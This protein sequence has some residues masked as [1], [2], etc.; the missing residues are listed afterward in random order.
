MPGKSDFK[1]K[2]DETLESD[3]CCPF[4]RDF[5]LV[6]NGMLKS[7][8]IVVSEAKKSHL[9]KVSSSITE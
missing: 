8:E 4:P 2:V 7:V 6:T 1:R 3:V 5:V 9:D